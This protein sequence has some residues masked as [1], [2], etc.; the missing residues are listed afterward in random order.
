MQVRNADVKV[1]FP[2]EFVSHCD[3]V[4]EMKAFKDWVAGFDHDF[5]LKSITIQSVDVGTDEKIDFVKFKAD[6]SDMDGATIPGIVFM[7]GS[8]DAILF[9]IRTEEDTKELHTILT[10]QPRLAIGKTAY[11]E[12]PTGEIIKSDDPN[13]S[14]FNGECADALRAVDITVSG[15]RP[16]HLSPEPR[17]RPNVPRR[18]T[19]RALWTSPR[20]LSRGTG[21]W[22]SATDWACTRRVEGPMRAS[23]STPAA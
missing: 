21:K 22:V 3:K 23:S 7:R 11:P 18:S 10:V 2:P 15:A 20:G 13:S 6:V 16:H 1:F 14:S 19:S 17:R 5:E 4:L 9:I 8:S 12:I